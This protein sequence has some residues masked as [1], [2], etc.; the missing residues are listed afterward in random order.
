[1]L[2]FK[3]YLSLTLSCLEVH[4]NAPRRE[5]FIVQIVVASL[6]PTSRGWA[7]SAPSRIIR[8]HTT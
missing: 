6:S 7:D 5:D 8:R 4:R 1:M 2:Q 3:F